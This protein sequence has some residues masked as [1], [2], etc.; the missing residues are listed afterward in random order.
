MSCQYPIEQQPV[1]LLDFVDVDSFAVVADSTPF[2][3]YSG[4]SDHWRS[5]MLLPWL[6]LKYLQLR[7]LGSFVE[8]MLY[9]YDY[10]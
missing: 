10:Y 5:M 7:R 6:L 3:G 4:L 8:L 2:E 9:Y 1:V